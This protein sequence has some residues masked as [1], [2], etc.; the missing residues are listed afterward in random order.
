MSSTSYISLL[1]Y[2]KSLK[3]NLFL[4]Y[5]HMFKYYIANFSVYFRYAMQKLHLPIKLKGSS[6]YVSSP[7]SSLLI[8]WGMN[9]MINRYKEALKL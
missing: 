1:N 6:K 7:I 9:E 8:L 4:Y 3:R 2:S 5:T